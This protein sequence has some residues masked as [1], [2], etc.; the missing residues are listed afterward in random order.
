M[1]WKELEPKTIEL[2]NGLLTTIKAITEG[3]KAENLP[4]VDPS[5]TATAQLIA[6]PSYD[7]VVCGEVKKGKSSFINALVGQEILPVNVKETTSQV[8]RVTNSEEESFGLVFTDGTRKDISRDQLSHYGS[9]VDADLSGE[10]V[11]E[12][13]VLDYI[14]VNIPIDF[15]PQGV[16]LVDT[17]GLGALYKSHESITNRYIQ[18][19]SA[20]IFVFNP[21]NPM[22]QQEKEFLDKVFEVT[23]YV[24][25]V[26]TKIDT[27]SE[28][29]WVNQI[30]RDEV[31]LQE[32]FTDK[33]HE[34]PKIFPISS[35]NL[36][37]A[38]KE[39]NATLKAVRMKCSYFPGMLEELQKIMYKTVGIS[40]TRLAY[41]QVQKQTL[42]T[43]SVIEEQIKIVSASTKKEQDA[44]KYKRV[45][46][47]EAFEKDWGSASIKRKEV[48][49]NVKD[50]ITSMHGKVQVLTSVH[51][52]VYKSYDSK[53]DD[54]TTMDE[55]RSFAD[56]M[57]TWVMHDVS[58]QWQ[59]I[60]SKAQQDIM[61]LLGQFKVDM[62]K[63]I[64]KGSL[65]VRDNSIAT[66]EL[67]GKELF[68]NFKMNMFDASMIGGIGLNLA[69]LIGGAAIFP[70]AAPIVF[71]GA[72]IW[73]LFGGGNSKKEVERN[74]SLFRQELSKL[75]GD[76]GTKLMTLPMENSN[77][78][79][80]QHFVY[81][82]ST[83]ADSALTS[84]YQSQK[85]KFE[86]EDKQLEEA[87]RLG[88]D[89]KQKQLISLNTQRTVWNGLAGQVNAE[90]ELLN[91]IESVFKMKE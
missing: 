89:Q 66:A 84:I 59:S 11:F 26:M 4:D 81:Q 17:P 9:Q 33:C 30:R 80:V 64:V 32:A 73:G 45:E 25:F 22:V 62:E 23:S 10:P 55:V 79:M 50:I 2:R 63:V 14:Q 51:G 56:N 34:I 42:L 15:L 87:A 53:I 13:R 46:I 24:M 40:R 5:F 60:A 20:V 27:C 21:G 12:N 1:N 88:A 3:S 6:N 65:L 77:R 68:Q 83:T 69:A 47:R 19:A 16:S 72:L 31:L 36:F 75:L 44:I 82:L 7:I 38:A 35:M 54:L 76:L 18:N 70:I 39:S 71:V 43:R 74:K 48:L 67:S 91:E 57:P 86:Q 29:D 78:S 52:S 49:Q 8:F 58:S 41:A 85:S 37:K 28:E 90:A 61:V